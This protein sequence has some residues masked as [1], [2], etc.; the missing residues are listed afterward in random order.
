MSKTPPMGDVE[1]AFW[2]VAQTTSTGSFH[3]EKQQLCPELLPD[4]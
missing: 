1:M 3:A 2:P 4:G